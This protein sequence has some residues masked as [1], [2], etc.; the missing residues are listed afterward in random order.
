MGA[1]SSATEDGLQADEKTLGMQS[2]IVHQKRDSAVKAA[3][4]EPS[5]APDRM[6]EL[7]EEAKEIAGLLR[8][9]GRSAFNDE[10][11]PETKK[12]DKKPW[13]NW[14]K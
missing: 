1:I 4:Q 13:K 12:A 5:L 6:R 9:T 7:L 10:L 8:W 2:S 14:K 3:L 11:P